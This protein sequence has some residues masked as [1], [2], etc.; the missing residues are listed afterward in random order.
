MIPK[1]LTA[2]ALAFA[3][4]GSGA[5]MAVDIATAGPSDIGRVTVSGHELLVDGEKPGSPFF[6]VVDTTVL[7]HATQAYVNGDMSVAGKSSVFNGPDTGD[8][9]EVTPNGDPDEFWNQYFGQMATY[10][11]NLVR[12]GPGDSWGSQIQHR[13]WTEHHDEY[14]SLL[15]SMC[16]HAEAHGVHL[17]LVT[18]GSQEFPAYGY[19]G[20]GTVFDP[21]SEAFRNYAAFCR[22]IMAEF[23]DEDVIAMYDLFNEPDHNYVNAAYWKGDKL[24]FNAWAVALAEATEGASTHPRTLGVAGYCDLFGWGQEDFDLATG[25]TGF[26]VAHRHFYASAQDANLYTEPEEW[27]DADGI[28]LYWG[29][30]AH[31]GA[32]PLTR[33]DFA[34]QAIYAAGGQAITSMVL[35][36][37]DG[38]PYKGGDIARPEGSADDDETGDVEISMDVLAKR[39]GATDVEFHA[40]ASE[41][42]QVTWEFDDG[43]KASGQTVQKTLGVGSHKVKVTVISATG[44]YTGEKAVSVGANGESSPVSAFAVGTGRDGTTLTSVIGG[45][46][47][48]ALVGLSMLSYFDRRRLF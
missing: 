5:L 2:C 9:D 35:T 44:T 32:Y 45:L 18:G 22:E 6:G 33:F 7:A 41:G 19:G 30:L 11:V 29:E 31:N 46:A 15:R 8:H 34:E 48:V 39:L 4:I 23:E 24:A 43:S 3:F 14:V 25:K 12:I 10:D 21:E 47:L 36:G 16:R 40:D 28:P 42:D 20:S 37:T 38:Y 17:V 13:A 27:A 26:E 1:T